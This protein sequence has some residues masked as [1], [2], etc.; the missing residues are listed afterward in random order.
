MTGA[1]N[2]TASDVGALPSSTAIPSKTSDLTNDS[3]YL[4]YP[5]TISNADQLLSTSDIENQVPYLLRQ[6]PSGVG[7][8]LSESIVGG[9]VAWNQLVQNGNFALGLSYWT[10]SGGNA[11]ISASDGELTVTVGG[12]WNNDARQSLSTVANHVYLGIMQAKSADIA[13]TVYLTQ[14]GITN[15]V[16]FGTG[17]VGASYN[18]IAGVSKAIESAGLI[19]VTLGMVGTAYVGKSFTVKNVNLFDL[20]QMFGT[21]VADYIYSLEQS[22]TGAGVAYFRKLFP[23]DYYEYNAGEL[24]SVEGLQSHDMVGFNQ[25]DEEWELGAINS[26]TGQPYSSSTSI[27]CKNFIPV[28]PNTAYCYHNGSETNQAP[29]Y[30]DAEKNFV[31]RS[32]SYVANGGVFTIPDNVHYMKFALPASYGTTYNHDICINISSDRNGEYEPYIKHSYPLDSSLTLRGIPKLSDGL[33]FDGDTYEA[34]GTVTRKY[35]IR[36]FDGSETWAARGVQGSYFCQDKSFVA[37]NAQTQTTNKNLISNT[38]PSET[39]GGSQSTDKVVSPYFYQGLHI[40]DTSFADVTALKEYLSQHPITV[41]YEL[42]TPTTESATPY[43]DPQTVISGGSESYT[44]DSSADVILPVG[45]DS[46]YTK[47]LRGKLE[48]L[49]DSFATVATS[50]SYNDLTN[51]PTNA[52]ISSAGLMSATDK[53]RLDDLY[54]DYSS[55]LTALGV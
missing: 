41:V 4:T 12:D 48:G 47:D 26:T 42:A 14:V 24:M 45:H 39:W 37:L 51:K 17:T 46:K 9:T 28:L 27:R 34:D 15:R 43:A 23:K 19:R 44:V 31:K 10:S 6:T 16:S 49:P 2:L 3:G 11:S 13:G 38:Y 30:Y 20:T 22:S 1:V 40:H 5:D 7:N 25:W 55:A 35:G 21:S 18:T 29:W 53:S 33:Y 36:V 50:G 32:S 8:R 52:T 54:A